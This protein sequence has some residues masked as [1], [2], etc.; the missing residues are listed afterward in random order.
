MA[1]KKGAITGVSPFDDAKWRAESD[2][3]TLTQAIEIRK[4][5][6]RMKAASKLAKEKVAEMA[7]IANSGKDE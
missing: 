1:K 5:P 6:K 4:D 7:S 2:L 3:N